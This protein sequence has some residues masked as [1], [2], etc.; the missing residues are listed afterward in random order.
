MAVLPRLKNRF[1]MLIPAYWACLFDETMTIINQPAAYWK[2]D[3][4]K[5]NEANPIG[6]TLMKNH[7]SGL[8][9]I[10]FAW[11]IV[12]GVTGY[13]LPERFLKTF[14][15]VI[16]IA[17]TSAAIGWITTHYGYW[18]SIVF[19]VINSVL[20]IRFEKV[21]LQNLGSIHPK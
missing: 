14:A 8:F 6:A 2:G 1:T 4:T 5:A 18:Y 20:F 7:V 19:I 12:I 17:H 21:Y 16:L 3:L 11:L 9:L 13:F 10:S 15:L